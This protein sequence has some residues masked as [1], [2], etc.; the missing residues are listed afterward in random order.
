M[1]SVGALIVDAV[2]D[3][4]PAG[5]GITRGA[6]NVFRLLEQEIKSFMKL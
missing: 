1:I 3:I 6:R 2:K 5:Q 4:A